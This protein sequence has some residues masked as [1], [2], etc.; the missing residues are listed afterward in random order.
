[1]KKSFRRIL[2]KQR[3]LEGLPVSTDPQAGKG[4]VSAPPPCVSPAIFTVRCACGREYSAGE[5]SQL[6][7][8]G[9]QRVPCEVSLELR[10]CFCGSTLSREVMS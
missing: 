4:R 6:R 3:R 7:F 5:W 9:I 1:M 2:N 10:D 8:V